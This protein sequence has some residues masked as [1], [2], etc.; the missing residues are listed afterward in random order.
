MI[1]SILDTDLYKLTMQQAVSQKFPHAEAKFEFINRGNH[2]FTEE[3]AVSIRRNIDKMIQLNLT[4]EEG[5]FLEEKCTFLNPVYCDFLN[6]F[7]FNP[8]EVDVE[9]TEENKLKI[10]VEGPWYRTILWEVPIMSIISVVYN[11]HYHPTYE[12]DD[13]YDLD[14]FHRLLLDEHPY[15]I[16]FADFGTRRRLNYWNQDRIIRIAKSLPNFVGTS[17]VHFAQKYN[18]TPIGTHAHEW[19]M[20]HGAKY[21]YKEA[22]HLALKHWA[23]VYEGN[24]GIALSDTYTTK[25]FFKDFNSK[26]A[27]LFDGVRHDS[28]CPFEFA[29]KV[30]QHYEKLGIDPETKTIVF[31]DGVDVDLALELKDHIGGRIKYSF[32][33]GTNLTNDIKGIKPMNMVIKMTECRSNKNLPWSPTVKLSDT[34]GKNTGN[35]EEIELCKKTL[36]I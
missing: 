33:I 7:Q 6:G 10:R 18:L 30:I 36:Q 16:L 12:W 34:E 19:F 31:S 22:N 27:R 21:G 15:K 11:R 25:T 28:G 29:N 9:Y 17:N 32:G 5:Y 24:L 26:Y 13:H 20:F 4:G 14:K 8:D 35:P 1:N 2:K 23:E 3:M